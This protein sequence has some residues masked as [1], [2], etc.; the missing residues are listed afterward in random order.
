MTNKQF[1]ENDTSF[2]G[3]L[4]DNINQLAQVTYDGKELKE[5]VEHHI[6][7][8]KQN[9]MNYFQWLKANTKIK[10]ATFELFWFSLY[11]L[12]VIGII[13]LAI[14]DS[15]RNILGLALVAP[16]IYHQWKRYDTNK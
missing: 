2:H 8:L 4:I 6:E 10:K 14:T 3:E 15:W 12:A 16:M 5:Y 7:C 1:C 11:I 13:Y 9:K